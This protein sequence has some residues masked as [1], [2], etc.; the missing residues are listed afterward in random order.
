MLSLFCVLVVVA[1]PTI[2]ASR[3]VT[4][5]ILNETICFIYL[6]PFRFAVVLGMISS[7]RENSRGP[8]GFARVSDA[9]RVV[10]QRMST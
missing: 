9:P 7:A 4:L 8:L 5:I 1:Q 10:T 3:A 6:V 2:S